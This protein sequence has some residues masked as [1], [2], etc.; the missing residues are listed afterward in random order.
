MSIVIVDTNVWLSYLM[1]SRADST[2]VRVIHH[3]LTDAVTLLV[4]QE[5]VTEL[6]HTLATK[7]YFQRRI[8]QQQTD[9]FIQALL[10]SA[11][12]PPQLRSVG[13]YVTDP[14]D[15]FL[16]AYGLAYDADYVVTGDAAVLAL[17]QVDNMKIV[18]PT[19][20]LKELSAS[21]E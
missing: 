14:N 15:D 1:S 5:L 8:S 2:I 20:F 21:A 10:E 11:E 19:R 4:P 18:S 17:G 3:C 9:A 12:I 6:R 13:Q 7:P 16:I